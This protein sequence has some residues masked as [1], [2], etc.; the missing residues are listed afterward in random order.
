[1]PSANYLNYLY[2]K[3]NSQRF[4]R[5]LAELQFGPGGSYDRRNQT[6]EKIANLQ[7][8]PGGASDRTIAGHRDVANI[9]YGPGGASDR[10][11]LA[12]MQRYKLAYGPGSGYAEKNLGEGA[13]EQALATSIGLKNRLN[14]ELYPENVAHERSTMGLETRINQDLLK[15]RDVAAP[16]RRYADWYKPGQFTT[17]AN[18]LAEPTTFM[19]SKVRF[20]PLRSLLGAFDAPYSLWDSLF[21][22]D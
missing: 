5:S 16:K 12:T 11:A 9:Q 15:G 3:E 14:T 22:N 21:A 20:K 19:G 10:D 1:M 13:R 6:E 2:D 17:G 4:K 7:Y 8:A 18:E